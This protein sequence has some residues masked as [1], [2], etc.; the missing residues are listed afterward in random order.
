[1]NPL[2][3]STDKKGAEVSNKNKFLK[4]LS[5]ENRK[6][7]LDLEKTYHVRVRRFKKVISNPLYINKYSIYPG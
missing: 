1:M 2:L 5:P 3:L 6:M 7:A 4:F